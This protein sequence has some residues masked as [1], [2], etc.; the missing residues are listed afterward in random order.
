MSLVL[1]SLCMIKTLY[2]RCVRKFYN[3]P[4]LI[5][6]KH[7]SGFQ[8][9]AIHQRV[10]ETQPVAACSNIYLYFIRMRTAIV[11]QFSLKNENPFIGRS[12]KTPPLTRPRKRGGITCL[13]V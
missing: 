13:M 12:T 5:K 9:G 1:I 8:L 10:K 2:R 4:E 7:Y 6:A 11:C 3:P